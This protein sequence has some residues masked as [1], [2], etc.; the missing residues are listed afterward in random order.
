[1]L[2]GPNISRPPLWFANDG[3]GIAITG[4]GVDPATSAPGVAAYRSTVSVPA[5]SVKNT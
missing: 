5:A 3:C 4:V 2:S 1:M